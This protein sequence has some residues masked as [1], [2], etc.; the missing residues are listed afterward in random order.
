MA[1]GM[2]T[3]HVQPEAVEARYSHHPRIV[4]GSVKD[5]HCEGGRAVHNGVSRVQHAAHQQIDELIGA[6]AHLR[7]GAMMV[8]D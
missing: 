5:I 6:A 8:S 7:V 3:F 1:A 4:Y 2:C